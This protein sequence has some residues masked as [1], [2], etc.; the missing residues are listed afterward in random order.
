MNSPAADLKDLVVAAGLGVFAASSGWGVFVSREPESPDTCITLY[1]TGGFAPSPHLFEDR[2]TVQARVRGPMLGYQQGWAKA[3]AVR[4]ALL[5]KRA[6]VNGTWYAGIWSQGDIA[7][8]RYDE[9]NHPIWT[10]SFR[11]VRG[12][13]TSA[14]RT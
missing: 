13:P 3:L 6:L 14:H 9:A 2:P 7:F 10:M 12:A 5:G 1:D 8:L 4:E 11:I